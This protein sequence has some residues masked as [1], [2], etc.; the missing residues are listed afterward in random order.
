MSDTIP[1]LPE[2]MVWYDRKVGQAILA[3]SCPDGCEKLT[4]VIEIGADEVL[5]EVF[6]TFAEAQAYIDGAHF[7]SEGNINVQIASISGY[8]VAMTIYYAKPNGSGR[9]HVSDRR[10]GF[11]EAIRVSAATM[12]AHERM[13][14]AD[15]LLASIRSA[16]EPAP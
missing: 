1:D 15:R 13:A 11:V 16:L 6:S 3:S 14:L 5:V 12:S 4:D 10:N 2:T 7:E 8:G 9:V